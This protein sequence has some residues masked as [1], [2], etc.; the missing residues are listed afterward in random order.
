MTRALPWAMA[1]GLGAFHGLNPAMGWLFAV[2]LGYQEEKRRAIFEAI[3]ALAT[4][5]C[6]AVG[7][8]VILFWAAGAWLPSHWIAVGSAGLLVGFGL[9]WLLRPRHPRWVGMHVRLRELVLWA[10]LMATA[11]GAGLMLFPALGAASLCG[12]GGSRLPV[13][14]ALGMAAIHTI[15]YW[16]VALG[17]ALIVFEKVGLSFLRKAWWNLDVLWGTA[18]LLAAGTLLLYP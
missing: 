9:Y 17:M 4:G 2:A 10:F 13:G 5:H 1:F 16:A 11:H 3:G 8:A 14:S 7:A 6:L 18:L 12:Q 15:G